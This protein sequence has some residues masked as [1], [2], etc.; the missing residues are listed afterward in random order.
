VAVESSLEFECA[1]IGSMEAEGSDLKSSY[2]S[3]IDRWKNIGYR[4]S[5]VQRIKFTISISMEY[6]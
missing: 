3:H 1:K 6:K 2:L 4:T 5:L